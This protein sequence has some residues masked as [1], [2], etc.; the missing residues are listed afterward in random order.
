MSHSQKL[1]NSK[2][3][4]HDKCKVAE[5][6]VEADRKLRQML[7]WSDTENKFAECLKK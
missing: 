5:I 1:Q 3:T 2:E 4:K 6:I 7:E